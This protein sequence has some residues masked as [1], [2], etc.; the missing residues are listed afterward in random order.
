MHFFV[1]NVH[2]GLWVEASIGKNK[3][4]TNQHQKRSL[5]PRETG[6]LTSHKY[7]QK[8]EPTGSTWFSL[9]SLSKQSK[10]NSFF[11]VSHVWTQ[12]CQTKIPCGDCYRGYCTLTLCFL[13]EGLRSHEALSETHLKGLLLVVWD[14][15]LLKQLVYWLNWSFFSL[16]QP[17]YWLES[18]S[19]LRVLLLIG[20][21]VP[22]LGG[23]L[24]F[25]LLRHMW[26]QQ[27]HVDVEQNK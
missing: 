20:D 22:K 14:V 21:M 24:W 26:R 12:D 4:E 10:V 13:S 19:K 11:N 25:G 8:E 15:L 5:Y 1:C 23:T 27:L 7:Q 18:V 17:L 16:K 2:V 9:A 3:T 6:L